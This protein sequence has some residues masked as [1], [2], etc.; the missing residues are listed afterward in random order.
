MRANVKFG[1]FLR[2]FEHDIEIRG[3]HIEKTFNQY[4]QNP[5]S[6]QSE[7]VGQNTSG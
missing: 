7:H 5:T 1:L 6:R 4:Q 3:S 2:F